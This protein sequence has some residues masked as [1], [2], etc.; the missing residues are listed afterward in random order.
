V[1]RK[2]GKPKLPRG[3]GTG[4]ATCQQCGQEFV[5]R[6]SEVEKGDGRF[7]SMRCVYADLSG[8]ARAVD[9]FWSRVDRTETCW[10][11]RPAVRSNGYGAVKYQGRTLRAS[12]LSW[13]LHHGPV[14]DRLWV[15]H[16]CD[17]PPCVNPDHLFLGNR[18]DN[19]RDAAAKGRLDQQLNPLRR[20][21]AR[22]PF[23]PD[24]VRSVRSR[25]AGGGITMEQLGSEFGVTKHAIWRI[26]HRLNWSDITC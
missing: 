4:P 21:A 12:H 3:S 14:P 22:S 7:C 2:D 9:R 11:Y 16:R 18:S 8:P 24:D 1:K 26:V 10:L 6:L 17:T 25:Y 5:A 13:T 15:L 23:T 20:R 19:M